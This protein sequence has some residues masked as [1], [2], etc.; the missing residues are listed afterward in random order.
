[1]VVTACC[2]RHIYQLYERLHKT[3]TKLE[4]GYV[5]SV[6]LISALSGTSGDGALLNFVQQNGF[7]TAG[8]LALWK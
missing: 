3:S 7:W 1:M 2:M 8:E 5:N 6:V 4:V